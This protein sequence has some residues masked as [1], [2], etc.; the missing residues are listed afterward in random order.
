[1]DRPHR[2]LRVAVVAKQVVHGQPVLPAFAM[3]DA[4]AGLWGAVAALTPLRA[5]EV[6]GGP[7][8]VIDLS[9]IEPM[10]AVLGPKAAEFRLSGRTTPRLGSR[11]ID[12]G[13]A[14][15]LP[16][17]GRQ[18][19]RALDRHPGHG[20]APVPGDRPARAERRSALSH[21]R[22]P[23]DP[24]RGGR[25][26]RR[27]LHRRTQTTRPTSPPTLMSPSPRCWSRCRTTP[28]A[29]CRCTT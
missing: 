18:V 6:G 26:D 7:G 9:L 20:R 24:S 12:P 28:R 8:Q 17:R 25:G 10:L 27:R 29:A 21:Q 2:A 1:M 5:V 3:A 22:R 13:A 15:R 23:A 16:G 11:C 19:R 14:R 4:F